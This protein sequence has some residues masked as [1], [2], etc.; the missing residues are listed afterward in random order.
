M[1]IKKE[2]VLAAYET[3]RKAGA[4]STMK[5]LEQLF[6]EETF[7]PKDITER[8]KTFEDACRELGEEHPLVQAYRQLFENATCEDY[9]R[10]TFGADMVAYLKLRIIC[11]ALNE[12]WEP[13]FTEDEWRYYPWFWL[14]TQAEIDR[15]DEEERQDRRMMSTGDYQTGYAGFACASS[16]SAPSHSDAYFGSRLCLKSDTLAVYCGKQFIDLWADFYLI[17]K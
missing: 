5:V 9:M 12:G 4:D 8:V 14:Y 6:G 16:Y 1:E 10:E 2:N 7:K 15:M 11:A 13:Q 3:A 17:R